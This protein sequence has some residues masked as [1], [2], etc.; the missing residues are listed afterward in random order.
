LT[1]ISRARGGGGICA[2]YLSGITK[3]TEVLY[4]AACPV[5]SREVNHYAKLSADQALPIRYDDLNDADRLSNWGITPDEAARRLHVRKDGEVTSGIP[6]FILLWREIPQT[7]WLAK[8]FNLPVVHRVACLGYD[9]VLAPLIYRWHLVRVR[10][11]EI[12]A[13][14]QTDEIGT[15]LIVTVWVVC[16]IF[17]SCKQNCVYEREH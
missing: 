13:R 5:C 7:Q 12:K 8:L 4:N 9:Y 1:E 16:R 14:S 17:L 15:C 10:R 2:A 3:K 6:A 11:Q